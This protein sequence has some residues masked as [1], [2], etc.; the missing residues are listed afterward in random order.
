MAETLAAPI[1]FEVIIETIL[2]I[3]AVSGLGVWLVNRRKV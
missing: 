3:V 2:V 1:P